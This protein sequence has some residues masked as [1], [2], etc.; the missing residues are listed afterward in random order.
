MTP[1]NLKLLNLLTELDKIIVGDWVLIGGG[2]LGL[3]RD[4]KFIDW[5]NDLDIYI[6]PGGTIDKSKL[7]KYCGLQKYY[8]DTKFFYKSGFEG[9][10]LYKP[11]NKWL[12]F[13]GYVRTIPAMIGKNRAEVLKESSRR[14]L[15]E[16]IIPEFTDLF[17]DIYYLREDGS[18]PFFPKFN[19]KPA[20]FNNIIYYE[21]NEKKIP[22]PRNTKAVLARHYGPDWQTPKK[23]KNS[24]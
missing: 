8:M 10:E 6:L 22:I 5:D 4:D 20:E 2:L 21:K 9:A 16:Y 13:I 24:Y 7:P 15:L 11:K 3:I 1:K 17:I 19:L 12:E 18:I 23:E 14:Y